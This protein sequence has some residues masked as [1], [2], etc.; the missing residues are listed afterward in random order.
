MNTGT[1]IIIAGIGIYGVNK[2][3]SLAR[4]ATKI[5]QNLSVN[6]SA[7]DFT[8]VNATT[9]RSNL[10]AS[11]TNV[12]GFS[13]TIKNLFSRLQLVSVSGSVIDAGQST[14]IPSLQF[15]NNATKSFSMSFDFSYLTI[16]A[17][18]LA[19]SIKT[20]RVVTYYDYAGQQLNYTTEIPL[21]DYISKAKAFV[22][23]KSKST[24]GG[25]ANL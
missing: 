20:V 17:K 22:S 7:E 9:A 23:G 25:V 11:L 19:G 16:I 1:K 8:L 14:V 6:V 4:K 2:A 10:K 12:S 15:S 18:L 21:S 24:S 5:E 13:F 3:I